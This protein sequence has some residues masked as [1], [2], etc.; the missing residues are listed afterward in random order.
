MKL[1]ADHGGETYDMKGGLVCFLIQ[2]MQSN[3][4]K[5]KMSRPGKAHECAKI[6]PVLCIPH[7]HRDFSRQS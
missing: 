3:I 6:R 1:S 2:R 5:T 7:S 4:W